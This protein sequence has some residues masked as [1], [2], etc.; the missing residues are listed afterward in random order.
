[1]TSL[2]AA[3]L[4]A[5]AAQPQDSVRWRQEG[6]KTVIDAAN[7]TT[8]EDGDTTIT[9]LTGGVSVRRPD[10]TLQ[11]GR[12]LL[13]RRKNSPEIY[14]EIYA[15]GN[16]IFT[17]GTQKMNCERFFYSN[18]KE[19]GAIVDVR[20]KAY[21]KELLSNF[22]AIAKE[23]RL[24]AKEGKMVADDVRL[25]SCSYGVPHYHLSIDHA[26]LLGGEQSAAAPKG[27]SGFSV[28]PDDWIVDFDELV[29]EFG[30]IPLIYL[31][32][33][34]VGPWLMN[35][36][37]RHV[38]VGHSRRFGN[39]VYTDFGSRIRIKDEKGKPRQW[40]DVDLKVDWR[41]VRGW[42]GGVDFNYKW[43]GYVGYLDSY[44]LHDLGR[45]GGS[46]F[47]AQ[48]PPL[49]HSD[50]GK[51]HWY[52]RHDL[53]EHWRYE[54]EAY[55]L[56]DRSLLEEFFPSEF[57]E[58]KQPESA[59]YV[60]W[61]DGDAGAFLLTRYRFN[62][63]LTQDEYL[64][65][66]DFNLLSH[67]I[68]GGLA[69]NIYL[70]ERFDVVNIRRRF[71]EALLL[72]SEQTWRVDLVTQLNAPFDF[73]YFQVAPY[74]QYRLTYYEEDLVGDSRARNM[75]TTGTR[76]TTQIH[77]THPDVA[78]ERAGIRGL[79]HVV[80]VEARYGN[81]F[82]TSVD[83]D[84]LF[85]YEPVD[86]LDRFEE[87][88]FEIRQR[89]LTKDAAN[90]PFEFLGVMLGIEYYPDSLRDTTSSRTSNFVPPFNWIPVT[91]NPSTG[92]FDRRQW[93]NV[94]Y[95]IQLTPR[96]LFSLSLSGQY[97]P[98]THSEE[99]REISFSF[100]PL[101]GFSGLL[102]QTRV[103]GVTDALSLGFTWA[104]TPK[105]SISVF[106]Q[107]D[108]KAGDYLRQE[109][110]VSRDFHDFAIEAVYEREFT[111]DED[112]FLVAFVP[113]FLGKSGLR[114]SH[115]YRPDVRYRNSAER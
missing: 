65:R 55:Y 67:P 63:F 59:A 14:D 75:W 22:F 105:W 46:A 48:L 98:E 73:R 49:L 62:D 71:D 82:F 39:F 24:Y 111:R 86:Q 70:T 53:D 102:G 8:L 33:L 45:R 17:R 43:A 6:Q 36:P 54:L 13:W 51:V 83:R 77:G 64:P 19:A 79:R 76:V 60:R 32:G 37:I 114:R 15:E 113:K 104:L 101:E 41:Q 74:I 29:P 84:D 16:V 34:T 115:L 106:G 47:D 21:S 18:L 91:S 72:P 12:A 92:V 38:R 10:S 96:S 87:V 66:V 93:S 99:Y 89:F 95:E 112:R 4:V 26:T 80:E 25:S 110:V 88:A 97:N 7:G 30:G 61:L 90:K 103:K 100:T 44:Y 57:K 108:F 85:P 11:A 81:N 69:D 2:V 28:M 56:S 107:Y 52:H 1:M 3:L 35:F 40:G 20:L 31:P 5:A 23:A 50:R 68:L 42:G 27:R 58:D 78:W 109:M 94:F 9:Y